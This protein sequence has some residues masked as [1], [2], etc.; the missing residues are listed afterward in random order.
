MAEMSKDALFGGQPAGQPANASA[1]EPAQS[2]GQPDLSAL[3]RAAVAESVPSVVNE[4]LEQY[5][6]K[7]Q[8]QRDQQE[9]R[10]NKRFQETLEIIRAT[11][12]EP[13]QEQQAA[14]RQRVAHAETSATPEPAPQPSQATPGQARPS[15]AGL[16]SDAKAELTQQVFEM[17][18]VKPE[19]GDPELATFKDTE[20]PTEFLKQLKSIAQAKKARL[21]AESRGRLGMVNASGPRADLSSQYAEEISKVPRGDVRAFL[22]VKEK[23]RNQGLNIT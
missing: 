6:R 21:E 7:Q 9:A 19:Q 5:S 11:G 23:Y 20:N 2:N 1:G 22:A 16:D 13:T 18:G 10:I 3:I 12:T 15:G 14:I 4:A 17:Y 8:S